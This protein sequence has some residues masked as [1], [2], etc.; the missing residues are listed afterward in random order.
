MKY[1]VYSYNSLVNKI[2]YISI[3]ICLNIFLQIIK[4]IDIFIDAKYK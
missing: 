1:Q 3:Y 4:A 2:M